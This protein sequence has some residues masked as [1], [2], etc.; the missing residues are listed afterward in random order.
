M[1]D[2]ETVFCASKFPWAHER[3]SKYIDNLATHLQK[4]SSVLP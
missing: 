4:G 2:C 3:I 1:E